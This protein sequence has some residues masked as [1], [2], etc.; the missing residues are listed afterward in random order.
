MSDAPDATQVA[1]AYA[2]TQ[3]R[4]ARRLAPEL[5]P[6]DPET[7]VPRLL[8]ALGARG[9]DAAVFRR[10]AQLLERH[11]A[12]A[13]LLAPVPLFDVLAPERVRITADGTLRAPRPLPG[14]SGPAGMGLQAL[15]GS[16]A[17]TQ[18]LLRRIDDG[19]QPGTE[20][21]AAPLAA[22]VDTLAA[23]GYADRTTLLRA[24]PAS[25][26]AGLIESVLTII[27]SSVGTPDEAAAETALRTQLDDLLDVCDW[28]ASQHGPEALALAED[29]EAR[30]DV[31]RARR[32]VQDQLAR[33]PADAG[34]L[35]RYGSLSRLDG[36]LATAEEALQE[37]LT[38]EPGHADT[39]I[40]LARTLLDRLELQACR[41]LLAVLPSGDARAQAIGT[42]ATAIARILEEAA[43][44]GALPRLA[45]SD[46][47][48]VGARL[49]PSTH[50]LAIA[51]FREHGV[52]QL[53]NVFAPDRI[54]SMQAAFRRQQARFLDGAG[55]HG[56]LGVGEGRFMLTMVLDEVFGSPDI[57][58]SGIYLPLMQELLGDECIL[59]AYTAVVSMPGSRDQSPHKDHSALFEEHGWPLALPSFAA[60]VVIPLLELNPV[61]G[62]TCVLKGSQQYAVP[63]AVEELAP[64][65]PVVPLGSCLL[66]DY[67]V[68]HYGRANLSGELRPILNLVYCRPWFRDCRNYH[69][70]PPLK[71]SDD[72]LERA[73]S[74][75][76]ALI[77]WWALERRAALLS[78][79]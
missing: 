30:G 61:T 5:S 56:V 79:G 35:R 57:V 44:P 68:A 39:R 2:R 26:T 78:M 76:R 53:D 29:Y 38:L 47:E 77:D 31:A 32:L 24:L 48:R 17:R 10:R 70:Q 66:I 20:P 64:A 63:G 71:F 51:L 12:A 8:R 28:L 34:L 73:P 54:E 52:L 72:F 60:Q 46:P 14:R 21:A 36:D 43:Q 6:T 11:L 42:R 75:L 59:G 40:E 69:L 1:R 41:E 13:G 58:C 65:D 25:L 49:E 19:T 55:E 23:E 18:V 45:L 4:A 3:A 22:L 7:L 37:A 27:E 33:N 9:E 74:R 50:A 15:A 16:C 62:A 67:S